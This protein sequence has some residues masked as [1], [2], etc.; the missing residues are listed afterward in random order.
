MQ[1]DQGSSLIVKAR[2]RPAIVLLLS[3]FSQVRMAWVPPLLFATARFISDVIRVVDMGAGVL[4][5]EHGV[6]K[7]IFRAH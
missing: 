6:A 7:G 3:S 5:N 1:L 2:L 4:L